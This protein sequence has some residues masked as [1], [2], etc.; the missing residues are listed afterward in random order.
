MSSNKLVLLPCAHAA[1][2]LY[3]VIPA[4]GSGDFAVSRGGVGTYFGANGTIQTAQA[5]E[6]RF[7]FD[8][9]TGDF[10][11]VLVEPASTNYITHSKTLA[12]FVNRNTTIQ[13]NA[14]DIPFASG[15]RGV[16]Y[17]RNTTGWESRI[18]FNTTSI[19]DGSL[20][21]YRIYAKYIDVQFLAFITDSSQIVFS[22][23]LVQ[24][25]LAYLV[26]GWSNVVPNSVHLKQLPEDWIEIK[27]KQTRRHSFDFQM[28]LN[29]NP[30]SLTSN[31]AANI[32]SCY[33]WQAQAENAPYQTSNIFTGASQV[34]R[35]ADLIT[36]STPSGL[37]EIREIVNGVENIVSSIPV[38]YQ[39]PDGN[40]SQ[41]KMT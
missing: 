13:S 30:Q 12:S 25:S 8:P 21:S 11:G 39:L 26:P 10:E 2:K 7:S 41:V 15:E 19:D 6:A 35:P 5:N 32:G 16:R 1:G 3:S 4:D 38:L 17:N 22:V 28:Q 40:V 33:L 37:S 31:S 9:A 27:W 20:F 34:T 14:V 36:V 23:D 18:Y 29:S 24:K